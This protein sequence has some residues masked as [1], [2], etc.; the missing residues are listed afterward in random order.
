MYKRL[1]QSEKAAYRAKDLTEQLLTFSTG[2]IASKETI[3]FK[4]LLNESGNM[5]FSGSE[6]IHTLNYKENNLNINADPGQL[7]QVISNLYINAKQAMTLGGLVTTTCELV[8]LGNNNPQNLKP[9]QYVKTSIEDEGAG[10]EEHN[11]RKI[12]DPYYTTKSTGHGL[13]LSTCYSLIKKHEGTIEVTSEVNKGTTF[14]LY[15]PATNEAAIDINSSDESFKTGHGKILVMDDE[16]TIGEYITTL[17]NKFG[18]TVDHVLRGEDT[19][20]LYQKGLRDKKPYDVVILDLTIKGGLGGKE[21]IE[22][23]LEIDPNVQA[24]VSSG[25][26]K[27]PIMENYK[28]FGFKV[29]VGK[30]YL[31]K[32]IFLAV[33][34]LLKV[35]EVKIK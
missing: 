12:F 6:I 27:D 33:S 28:K 35:P 30:P 8:I 22:K 14:Y 32:D 20:E 16:K 7:R 25:Y 5:A 19:I 1:D 13:G 15:L 11:L 23:L 17:F 9:G 31:S 2:N 21:T 24:I 26:S 29:A 18:Y 34:N 3:N 4:S 10:I